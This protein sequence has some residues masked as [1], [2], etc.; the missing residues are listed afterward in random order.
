MS[1]ITSM[2]PIRRTTLAAILALGVAGHPALAQIPAPP[3]QAKP[4][5]AATAAAPLSSASAATSTADIRDIRGPK[6][7]GAGW[8]LPIVVLAGLLV[9]GAAYGSY[10]W[11]RRRRAP[12][13]RTPAEVALARLAAAQ[14]LIE[15]GAGREFSIEVSSIVRDYI[16]TQFEVRAAHRTTDEFLHDLLDAAARFDP[17]QRALTAH[18]DSLAGFLETCDLAKFGGWNLSAA[19]METLR[20]GALRFVSE[21]APAAAAPAAAPGA[22]RPSSTASTTYAA[23]PST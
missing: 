1:R 9:G 11:S 18:R 23:F 14:A 2:K 12:L 7:L 3:Q 21:S 15:A 19:D 5:P 6:R 8:T 4:A 16:E 13:P 10:A 20:A 17:A 22:S